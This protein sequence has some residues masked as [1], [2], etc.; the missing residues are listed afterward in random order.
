MHAFSYA[1]VVEDSGP[2]ARARDGKALDVAI[3]LLKR[4][5]EAGPDSLEFVEALYFSMRL[6]ST[7]VEDLG[8]PEN[9][10]AKELRAALISVGN[11]AA[12]GNRAASHR[13]IEELQAYPGDQLDR[14]GRIA[15]SN[16]MRISLRAGE[17]LYINGAVLRANQRTT[18]E[19][20]NDAAFLLEAHV[21]QPEEATTPL[22]QLYFALQTLLLEP[23][24]ETAADAYRED[25][26]G[27]KRVLL[28]ERCRCR[29]FGLSGSWS[30]PAESFEALKT[31]RNLFPIEESILGASEIDPQKVA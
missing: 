13:R 20:L 12:A 18:I 7:F 26:P 21:I 23:S 28:H 11:W 16:P 3:S 2:A 1:E 5:E 27:D 29:V 24:S 31:I 25:V 4:A 6:W 9:G 17:R 10:L 8:R 15:V 30:K 19:L 22:R 14:P